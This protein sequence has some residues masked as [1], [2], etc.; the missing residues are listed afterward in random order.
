MSPVRAS[1]APPASR[2]AG[3]VGSDDKG[4]PVGWLGA[5]WGQYRKH[6][7]WA[8]ALF[9][10]LPAVLLS[11]VVFAYRAHYPQP[12]VTEFPIAHTSTT[13]RPSASPARHPPTHRAV[14]TPAI[15]EPAPASL[16][17]VSAAPVTPPRTYTTGA[18]PTSST[19][20]PSP[21]RTR[22]S[23][24]PTPTSAAPAPDPTP[25]PSSTPPTPPPS[26]PPSESPTLASP[27]SGTPPPLPTDTLPLPG[28]P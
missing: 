2:P 9:V 10:L 6:P 22:P 14:I 17:P 7:W 3:A 24:A 12:T 23:P 26:S 28:S 4:T 21:S 27:P 25:P 11:G 5:D 13:A 8:L 18:A 19:P 1:P 16:E 15:P 20:R